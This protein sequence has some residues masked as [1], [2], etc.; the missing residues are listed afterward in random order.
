MKK[1][2]KT[3]RK[4][5]GYQDLPDNPSQLNREFVPQGVTKTD[6]MMSLI[7]APDPVHGIP[8]NDI[9]ML[10]K[11]KDKPE[12]Q[13]YIQQRIQVAHESVAGCDNPDDALKAVRG[14]KEDLFA[15]SERMR[16]SFAPAEEKQVDRS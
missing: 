14:Y 10:M 8:S 13:A 4:F 1:D 12:V 9:A 3:L 11:H 15:Y 7:Y 16:K 2:I 6:E 5:V